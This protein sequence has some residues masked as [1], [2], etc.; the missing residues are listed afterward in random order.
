MEPCNIKG[1][2]IQELEKYADQRG[3][4]SEFF[5]QDELEQSQWPQMGYVSMTEP[6]MSRGPHE[7]LNQTD[8]FVFLGL[9]E[10]ELYL[11]DNRPESVSF[12]QKD[13]V[14]IPKGKLVRIIIP[15]GI[16]HGYKNIGCHQGVIV[17]APNKLYKG[18]GE[19]GE[20]DEIRY[21]QNPDSPFKIE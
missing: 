20:I 11:W 2:L 12:Q 19:L 1:I 4:L 21:E 17:N 3:W 13:I 9:S 14:K 7:H 15:P 8:I 10:F 18:K 16:V 5:R 6:G